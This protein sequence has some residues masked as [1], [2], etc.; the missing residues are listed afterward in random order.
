MDVIVVNAKPLTRM[1]NIAEHLRQNLH[2]KIFINL[3]L[4]E[5]T[6]FKQY[7]KLLR[8]KMISLVKTLVSS[9][10]PSNFLSPSNAA[11]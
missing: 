7:T 11:R 10:K 5:K 3:F 6:I 8:N 2:N 4:Y 1:E 9:L